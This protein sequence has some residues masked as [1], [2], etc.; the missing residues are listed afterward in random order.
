MKTYILYGTVLFLFVAIS[1]GILAW[2][3]SHTNPLIKA[4]RRLAEE[5][6]RRQVFPYAFHFEMIE[7]EA[8]IYYMVFTE[9]EKLIGYTF[10]AEG[11]GY[12]GIIRT[13]VGL[14]EDMSINRISI[15]QQTETPGLGDKCLMPSF[16]NRFVG[17]RREGLLVDK[18]GGGI[19]SLT[20]ATITTRTIT[21]SIRDYIGFLE[22]ALLDV[23]SYFPTEM[24]EEDVASYVPTEMVEEDV[25]SR[26][27]T[28]M[29]ESGDDDEMDS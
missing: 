6:A 14:N 20:G 12:S 7:T 25:A 1:C 15:L 27:P 9:D 24:V 5:N 13:M 29:V 2:V 21:N 26:V 18:D 23:A 28:D 16:L 8:L 19:V 4:N 3:N 11:I 17:L 22:N 10:I